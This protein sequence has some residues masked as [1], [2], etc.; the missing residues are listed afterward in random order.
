MLRTIAF[1][2]L[3]ASLLSGCGTTPFAPQTTASAK[4]SASALETKAQVQIFDTI[5]RVDANGMRVVVMYWVRK[6]GSDREFRQLILDGVPAQDRVVY[7]SGYRPMHMALNGNNV[8]QNEATLLK[9][10][11]ELAALNYHTITKEQQQVVM[12]AYDIIMDQI[13]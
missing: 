12:L 13:H 11:R 2:V 3:A 9:I 8:I 1:F 4:A 6:E 7:R 5:K 10:S